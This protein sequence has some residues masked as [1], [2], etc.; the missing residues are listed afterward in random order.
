MAFGGWLGCKKDVELFTPIVGP[1]PLEE[2]NIQQFFEKVKPE[3]QYFN[4][5]TTDNTIV[6][7]EYGTRIHITADLGLIDSE[8]L[9]VDGDYE[10]EVIEIYEKA[11]MILGNM[12]T[13]SVE[14]KPLISGGELFLNFT[15]GN[16]IL[17][18]EQGKALMVEIPVID[19]ELWDNMELF[20]EGFS[21]FDSTFAWVQA[22]FNPDTWDNVSIGEWQES[23]SQTWIQGYQFV[24]EYLQWINCDAFVNSPEGTGQVCAELPEGY[25]II[26]TAAFVVFDNYQTVI[27][28]NYVSCR[29]QL[30]IGEPATI[31]T[32]TERGEGNYELGNES[33]IIQEDL[34]IDITPK[35]ISIENL[36]AVLNDL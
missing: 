1:L 10:L 19:S 14:S 23:G 15:Q 35:L 6:R 28:L 4:L 24:T 3:S 9:P 30:P 5:K 33:F 7:T 20:F 29:A 16:E 27:N 12:P 36:I 11:D 32:I 18:L 25:N 13:I 31:I 21:N 26:N 8:G 34:T 17:S 22:D 2:G